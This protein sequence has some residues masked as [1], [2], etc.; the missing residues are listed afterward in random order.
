MYVD[1]LTVLQIAWV[2]LELG[3]NDIFYNIIIM[4]YY[5]HA[6]IC[7]ALI[8]AGDDSFVSVVAVIRN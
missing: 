3:F 7:V 1:R 5:D 4:I 2:D 8:Q 6:S